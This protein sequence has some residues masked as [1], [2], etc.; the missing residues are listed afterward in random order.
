[1]LSL[2]CSGVRECFHSMPARLPKPPAA[3]KA[4]PPAAPEAATAPPAA[5]GA[6]LAEVAPA[7]KRPRVGDD[8][9]SAPAL[10]PTLPSEGTGQPAREVM[11]TVVPWVHAELPSVL[12]DMG[13]L[14]QDEDLFA[15][16]PLDIAKSSAGDISSYK[17]AWKPANC[18]TS[19]KQAGFYEAGGSGLWIDPEVAHEGTLPFADCGWDALVEVGTTQFVPVEHNGVERIR[20]PVTMCCWWRPGVLG[21]PKDGFPSGMVPLGGK[22]F[23]WAWY[24]EM[25]KAMDKNDQAKIKQLYEC[26]L[27]STILMFTTD[28]LEKVCEESI[29]MSETVRKSS[30]VASDSFV[31]FARKVVMLGQ[32]LSVKDMVQR[33]IRFHGGP[34]NNTMA[35]NRQADAV[36]FAW[37]RCSGEVA[38]LGSQTRA[39]RIDR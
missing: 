15:T 36:F 10:K 39:G 22:P 23:L 26:I 3:A 34:F 2:W 8:I 4:P 37:F 25:F 7:A 31:T 5:A 38:G 35:Q 14:K 6:D 30:Q 17:E 16:K 18:V 13:L 27:T 32:D 11:K 20:Y 9:A 33:D 21:L 19:C 29:K 24:L 28:K 12:R 1:M